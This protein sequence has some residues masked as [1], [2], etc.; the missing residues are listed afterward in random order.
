M[1][2]AFTTI[3]GTFYGTHYAYIP[4]IHTM[5]SH[6]FVLHKNPAYTN[7]IAEFLVCS[8]GYALLN[9][10]SNVQAEYRNILLNIFLK[11]IILR[12]LT[13]I[14]IFDLCE[15]INN[16][17]IISFFLIYNIIFLFVFFH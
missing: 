9:S 13:F 7:K 10:L 16:N 15:K 6:H 17:T 11:Y 4:R 8:S 3:Y 2:D 5:N 12:S 1:I 14:Y